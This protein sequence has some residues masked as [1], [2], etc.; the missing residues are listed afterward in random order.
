MVGWTLQ[1]QPVKLSIELPAANDRAPSRILAPDVTV[2]LREAARQRRE[3]TINVLA[4]CELEAVDAAVLQALLGTDALKV[5]AVKAV[6]TAEQYTDTV[7]TA[8]DAVETE[9]LKARFR[10]A[11]E[12]CLD[13]AVG[14]LNH[15]EALR[16][17]LLSR[18]GVY[19]AG[20]TNEYTIRIARNSLAKELEKLRPPAEPDPAEEQAVT[21]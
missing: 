8:V 3:G 6:L 21:A 18:R 17:D 19:S 15:L 16:A 10:S 4:T 20:R 11:E 2:G 9:V 13:A 12:R 14:I 1:G 7:M 5:E